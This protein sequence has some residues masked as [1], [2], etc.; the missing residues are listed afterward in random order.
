MLF[1]VFHLASTGRV[2]GQRHLTTFGSVR[3]VAVN[4]TAQGLL[5]GD[6]NGDGLADI[7]AYGGSTITIYYQTQAHGAW[8]TSTVRV[9]RPIRIAAAA[10]CNDDRIDD[11]AL[12]TDLPTEVQVY[13]GRARKGLSLAWRQP[14]EE[15]VS[16]VLVTNVN[17]D[18]KPDLLLWGEKKL[19]VKLFLGAGNGAFRPSD[20]LLGEFSLSALAVDDLNEDGIADL[21]SGDWVSNEVRVSIG[22]GQLRFSEPTVLPLDYEPTFV[23]T[24][25][26][27]HDAIKDIIVVSSPNRSCQIFSGDG[28]GAYVAS[29]VIPLGVP[30]TAVSV[31]DV[32]GDGAADLGVSSTIARCLTIGLNDGQGMIEELLKF[33]GGRAPL[34]YALFQHGKTRRIDAAILDTASHRLRIAL[35]ASLTDTTSAAVSE[36]LTGLAPAG[37]AASNG[38]SAHAGDLFVGNAAS[39]SVS[40]FQAKSGGGFTG[41]MSF[42]TV[43]KPTQLSQVWRNDTMAILLASDP[44]DRSASIVEIHTD[45]YSHRS[46]PL[47]LREGSDLVS[48]EAE[49]PSGSLKIL[50]LEHEARRSR[51]AVIEFE[52][53]APS[54]FIERT[55]TPQLPAALSA[56][57]GPRRAQRHARDL[58]FVR[59]NPRTSTEEVFL[60]QQEKPRQYSAPIL[61]FSLSVPESVGVLAWTGDLNGD[62]NDDLIL[63]LQ[64]P[65][66]AL[67][68]SLRQKDSTFAP[69]QGRLPGVTISYGQ[70]LQFADVNGDRQMD[71]L[72]ENSLSKSMFYLPGAG[73]GTFL[74][75]VRLISTEGVGG[76]AF[77]HRRHDGSPELLVTDQVQGVLRVISLDAEEE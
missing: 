69:P 40:Y 48:I 45:D 67:V 8:Q 41:Q 63:N 47:P 64:E 53:I 25:Y 13:L 49:G 62:G 43:T 11:I 70:D 3:D 35:N 29:A 36:Y 42:S 34:S 30:P 44:L 39:R 20:P 4:K 75:K 71:I 56:C 50:A 31:A 68:W 54:R 12:T 24:A 32:N 17:N 55:C 23:T 76:F 77:R 22:F 74:P 10:R 9:D 7:A 58:S 66:N 2:F 65:V 61:C 37:I 28:L 19:G 21:I 46:Y 16:H 59:Y 57:V 52:Q 33:S 5:T 15:P 1:F 26:F 38:R 18:R 51:S 6:F 60:L 27:N 73:A 72:F 14:V